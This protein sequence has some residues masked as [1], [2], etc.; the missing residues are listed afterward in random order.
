MIRVVLERQNP[1][2]AG[3][4]HRPGTAAGAGLP[5]V[6]AQARRDGTA[7]GGAAALE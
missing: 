1:A 3:G 6:P 2:G 5:E 7:P 4:A